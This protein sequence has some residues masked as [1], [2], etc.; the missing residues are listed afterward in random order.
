MVQLV[1]DKVEPWERKAWKWE[2]LAKEAAEELT[3]TTSIGRALEQETDA[4]NAQIRNMLQEVRT[5]SC[6]LFNLRLGTGFET[7]DPLTGNWRTDQRLG[8][9]DRGTHRETES[10]ARGPGRA[11]RCT[12]QCADRTDRST[13]GGW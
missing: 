9:G 2:A 1:E 7:C 5:V 8:G 3:I 6:S 10:R 4:K 11:C 13:H 12:H